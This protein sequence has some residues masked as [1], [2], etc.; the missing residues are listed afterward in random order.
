MARPGCL[1]GSEA[2]AASAQGRCQDDGGEWQQSR[3]LRA[4]KAEV[5]FG[6][7]ADCVDDAG[8]GFVNLRCPGS[9]A[10]GDASRFVGRAHLRLLS[11]I[12]EY[13]NGVCGA[14]RAMLQH[15]VLPYTSCLSYF[16]LKQRWRRFFC[17]FA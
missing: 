12:V 11:L 2:V 6:R 3:P 16:L 5:A 13:L 9:G 8:L 1:P 7:A 15:H 10:A 14:L 4:P 17:S